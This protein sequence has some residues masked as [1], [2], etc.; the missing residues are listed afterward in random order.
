MGI[1]PRGPGWQSVLLWPSL[2]SHEVC[3]PGV[4]TD[5][6]RENCVPK[7]LQGLQEM[8]RVPVTDEEK[9]MSASLKY[10]SLGISMFWTASLVLTVCY[11]RA[12]KEE[13]TYYLSSRAGVMA[14]FFK[15]MSCIF[16]AYKACK[17]TMRTPNQVLHDEIL[18]K[19]M[20]TLELV[21]PSG[22]HTFLNNLFYVA[23]TH[24]DAVTYQATYQL[25][26]LPTKLFSVSMLS[27]K[28]DVCTTVASN[29]YGRSSIWIVWSVLI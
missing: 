1:V 10:L 2:N 26:I 16:L 20:E 9:T 23:L 21:I 25:S 15:I 14:D 27:L 29:S 6:P 28:K 24:L 5:L 7:K 12:L 8:E 19:P 4:G 3:E 11:S 22:M 13:G 17:S 18:N